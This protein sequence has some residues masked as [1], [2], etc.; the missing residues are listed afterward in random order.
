MTARTEKQQRR[1]RAQTQSGNNTQTKYKINK[2]V[3]TAPDRQQ[4]SNVQHVQR[5]ELQHP[6]RNS[7]QNAKKKN[8]KNRAEET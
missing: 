7:A 8:K 5:V 6:E 3:I 2:G 4:K 1:P